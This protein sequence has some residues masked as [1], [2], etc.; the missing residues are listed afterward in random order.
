MVKQDNRAKKK[1]DYVL[2]AFIVFSFVCVSFFYTA[3]SALSNGQLPCTDGP[4][5]ICRRLF[6][7]NVSHART[8][9]PDLAVP[10]FIARS[11]QSLGL[12][13]GQLPRPRR[14][15]LQE[16]PDVCS[17]KKIPTISSTLYHWGFFLSILVAFS[18]PLGL[19]FWAALTPPPPPIT[20][21]PVLSLMCHWLHSQK[22]GASLA[23]R[24]LPEANTMDVD[25]TH[26]H[27]HSH[28]LS[29][30]ELLLLNVA[31][32]V[33]VQ[34]CKHSFPICLRGAS[35]SHSCKEWLE[36]ECA[37]GYKCRERKREKERER[38]WRRMWEP[39]VDRRMTRKREWWGAE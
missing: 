6:I 19:F 34:D 35:Q 1:T 9:Q 13:H 24:P 11:H 33:L 4:L 3:I 17:G 26:M 21:S 22:N 30:L 8:F 15:I 27:S 38:G 18:P 31:T 25:V 32:P 7:E 36:V 10:V 16:Q 2:C 29:L 12:G 14:E 5:L 39:E 28:T 20:P 37:R 23:Q